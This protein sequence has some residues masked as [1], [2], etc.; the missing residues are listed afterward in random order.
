MRFSDQFSVD[1]FCKE[2]NVNSTLIRQKAKRIFNILKAS[3]YWCLF[4]QKINLMLKFMI[5]ME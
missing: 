5:S 4:S 1:F 3:L 2:D